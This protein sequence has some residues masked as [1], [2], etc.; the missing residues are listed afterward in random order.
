M[1]SA[2]DLQANP[3]FLRQAS[4]KALRN[5][6]ADPVGFLRTNLLT[7]HAGNG[8]Q[9]VLTPGVPFMKDPN[10]NTVRIGAAYAG[11]ASVTVNCLVTSTRANA[12]AAMA[13]RLAGMQLFGL[14]AEQFWITD[15]QTGCTFVV[16]DWGMNQYSAL[17]V[18]PHVK[19]DFN[20]INKMLF[21]M[22]TQYDSTVKNSYLRGDAN[23]IVN[24]TT[25]AVGGG[26]RPQRYIMVQSQFSIGNQRTAQ[27]LGIKTGGQWD[28]YLQKGMAGHTG[29]VA[30]SAK[31]LQWRP[32]TDWAWR[33][34]E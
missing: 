23:S 22:S 17:H 25:A 7:V 14:G 31:Q 26:A 29:M 28:F 20:A 11:P 13:N 4:A 3:V 30:E 6:L 8:H 19:R 24:T 1:V 33:N 21:G 27:T 34:N 12:G 18:L 2:A 9:T 5:L 15:Q 10:Q 32:W 16:L